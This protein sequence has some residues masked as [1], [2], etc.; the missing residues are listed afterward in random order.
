MGDPWNENIYSL[1]Q[2]PAQQQQKQPRHFSKFKSSM[3]DEVT[4]TKAEYKTMGPAKVQT[5]PPNEFLKKHEKEPKLPEK[6]KFKYPNEE[7]RKPPVPKRDEQPILGLKTNKNFITQNAIE[8]IM[9]VPKKP[10]KN[11]ADTRKGD[12]HPLEPSG[13]EPKF[14]HKKD[15][16]KTPGYLERRKAELQR[17][18][19]EYNSYIAEHFRRG[20]MKQLNED[21]REDILNGLKSNWELLHHEYQGLSVVTDTAPKKNRKERMEAEMKQLERD[22]ESIEKHKIIYIAN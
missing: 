16:G 14:V 6:M 19:D 3:R 7:R 10:E 15:F 11:Y 1:I 20:A 9:A 8:N 5:R 12:K 13:L 2:Q 21:E 22:I 17:A 18:Q 4:K